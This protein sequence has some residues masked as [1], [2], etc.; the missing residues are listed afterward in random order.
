V[1][2]SNRRGATPTIVCG[3]P[4]IT[5]V[6]PTIPESAPSR[7]SQKW[8]DTTTTGCAPG[9]SSS[10]GESRRPR[11]GCTPSTGKYVP[12]TSSPCSA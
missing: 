2:P 4:F 3:F 9:V 8:C 11:K 10:A 12:D 6:L 1:V 5:S 7:I